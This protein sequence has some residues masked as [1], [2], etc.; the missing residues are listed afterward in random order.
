MVMTI[1]NSTDRDVAKKAKIKRIDQLMPEINKVPHFKLQPK[2]PTG[3]ANDTQ[4]KIALAE[5]R[6]MLKISEIKE[7]R[8]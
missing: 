4:G 2:A 5:F 7:F 6:K 3:T 8:R 1:A